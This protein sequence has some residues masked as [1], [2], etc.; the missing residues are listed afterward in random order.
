MA[1]TLQFRELEL[2]S[3]TT[4]NNASV[5]PIMAD[6]L[7]ST[8]V[9]QSASIV[10]PL[11]KTPALK[12]TNSSSKASGGGMIYLHLPWPSMG[13]T[14][15]YIGLDFEALIS[16]GDFPLLR[17]LE[18]DLK[19]AAVGASSSSISIPNIADLSAQLNM[20]EGGMWQI[21]N[22]AQEWTDTGIKNDLI[23]PDQW[24]SVSLRHW[25]DFSAGKF[26]VQ[27][28]QDTDT[29]SSMQSLPLLSS[30]WQPVIA[31]Q[32]QT[33]VLTPGGLSVLYRDI[34]VTL[35]DEAF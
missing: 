2:Q 30:N 35:S 5:N 6:N 16:S 20:A 31:V 24:F 32:L 9:E 29:P 12:F 8:V 13:S 3:W 34:T 27:S 14:L 15:Q 7:M 10:I 28:I 33:E 22:A 25:V 23:T 11:L 26:S 4:L 18:C 1:T 17:C 21:D 19:I